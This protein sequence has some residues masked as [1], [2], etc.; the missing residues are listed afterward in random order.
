[1]KA[2][3]IS[4]YIVEIYCILCSPI[5]TDLVLPRQEWTIR[6]LRGFFL[7][8]VEYMAR[9]CSS[10]AKDESNCNWKDKALPDTR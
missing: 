6:K 7:W 2:L 1:M 8:P 10:L 5:S 9:V 3:P 4:T